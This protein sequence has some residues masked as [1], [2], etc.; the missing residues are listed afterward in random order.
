MRIGWPARQMDQDRREKALEEFTHELNK[1]C[2]RHDIGFWALDRRL[3]NMED[4]EYGI[5][6]GVSGRFEL[7]EFGSAKMPY[8]MLR[9]KDDK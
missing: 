6:L 7:Y 3:F 8:A 9:W 1:L 4:D 2:E 5:K